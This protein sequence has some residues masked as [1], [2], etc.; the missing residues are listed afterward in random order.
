M[1]IQLIIL[2]I[3][4]LILFAIGIAASR[5]ISSME[6]FY[7]GG[8][9]L[10]Y[11]VVAFSARATGE[12]GWLLLGL[13]GM[14]AMAGFQAY[15]VVLGEL[16]GVALAWWLMA[17]PFKRLSDQY[18]SVTIPDF[19]ES[20]FKS[21]SKLLRIVAATALA[22]FVTIYISAQINATGVAFEQFLD[23]DFYTGAIVGF[24][25][26]LAYI[27]SG[28]FVAVA[29]SDLFQGLLMLFG[30]VA[31]PFVGLWVLDPGMAIVPSLQAIDPALTSVWGEGGFSLMTLFSTAGFLFIGIGFLGSPQIFVRFMAI[32]DEAE[33]E[34]GKWVAIAFTL[35]TDFAAVSIGILG[36]VLF[37]ENGQDAE[38][39]LGNSCESVLPMMVETFLSPVVIGLYIAIILSA[40]MS[41]IDSLLVVASSALVRDFY[42]KT[43]KPNA[44]HDNIVRVSR[45]VT[46]GLA[47]LSLI[48][49][50][51]VAYFVPG[52]TIFWFVVFGW[53]GIA[54]TFCPV[55]ILSL[56]YKGFTEKGAIASMIS[57]FLCVPIFKFVAPNLPVAGPYFAELAELTPSFIVA[58]L[59]G[60]FVS[61][62]TKKD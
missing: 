7:V 20:H 50:L 28:G 60:V 15:W 9:K 46:V 1:T 45:W 47:I 13:T 57:G 19:L 21:K 43:F 32:K 48:I 44:N 4:F 54:A 35:L 40:I 37:T 34:K 58:I 27:F 56:F 52:R 49:A 42:Q 36:R 61:S 59:L 6:D 22:L 16:L 3:Y 53:S 2:G 17:K 18:G 51:G 31:L 10:G 5:K 30:L 38:V 39:I 24:T 55:M 14:G 29:W 12:S 8:K 33:I 25:I 41:T 62:I 26:V 23:L 11:W